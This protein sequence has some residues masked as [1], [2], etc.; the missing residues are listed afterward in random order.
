MNPASGVAVAILEMQHTGAPGAEQ[1]CRP[2]VV[3]HETGA[4]V[5]MPVH[6]PGPG[7]VSA[8]ASK[9]ASKLGPSVGASSEPSIIG[10]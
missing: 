7:P 9:G 8:G 4:L 2:D 6:V 3:V 5:P 1:L 10:G